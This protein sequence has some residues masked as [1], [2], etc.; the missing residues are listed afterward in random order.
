MKT[1][2]YFFAL[3]T[4]FWA[5][6]QE[7]VT[8]TLPGFREIA[9][10]AGI[11]YRLALLPKE[12]GD[13]SP[14]GLYYRGC[15]VALGDYDGDG[16]DDIYFLNQLGRNALYRNKGDGTFVDVT[17]EA[18]VG[19]GDRIC[20]SATWADYDNS[21]RQS[22]F[23]TSTRGGNVLFKNRGDGTFVDVTRKAGLDLVAHSQ[24][25][26][27]FDYDNDGYLDLLVINTAQWTHN[28]IGN[29]N[30]QPAFGPFPAL[31]E[32]PK[33]RNR[34]YHNNRDGTFSDVTQ[35]S[36]LA[37]AGWSGDVAV[38]D[39]NEDGRLDLLITNMFG[40]SHLYRNN[41]DGTFT[42][43][44]KET[45]GRT[46]WGGMGARAFDFDNDGRLDLLIVDL[47]SDLWAL[48]GDEPAT[49]RQTARKRF[50]HVV[51]PRRKDVAPAVF[52]ARTREMA[53]R[54]DVRP[55]EVVFGNTL[56]RN[57]GGGKFQEV[58]EQA[59]METFL[60]WG[61]ATGDFDNDGY[62]DVFLPSGMGHPYFYWPNALMMN[63]GNGTFADRAGV[64]GIEPPAGGI[65]QVKK[66]DGKP[67][68]RCSRSAA[69]ADFRNDGRLDIVTNNFNDAP[70][71]FQNAFPRKNFLGFR[72]RGTKSNRDAI[73]VLVRLHLRT[74]DGRE[75]IMVRQVN[76]A[77]GYLAQSSKTIHF[78]LGERTKVDRVE[79]RWP[80]GIRQTINSPA[81]NRL[82]AVSEPD[83]G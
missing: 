27:F 25:A 42:D 5:S 10:Q 7:P 67:A 4:L 76:P 52:E 35:D 22:L 49:L 31:R 83:G 8:R 47:H 29:G 61:I 44:T 16:F 48:P 79:I 63:S 65:H 74:N 32:I 21:G 28:A 60:P 71:Y 56:F 75:E 55:N 50:P 45:L 59:S 13:A 58:S 69:V 6:E 2:A 51:G 1:A 43:V 68:A 66:I 14:V 37:G 33:E 12:P 38:F 62:Q 72:L 24:G 78:G 64:L 11:T 34:L 54:L 53:E 9:S 20:V 23:V 15:G 46:S 70:Y 77:G 3:C 18:G 17:K 30:N 73:G 80:S 82:H 41:G 19:L 26:C 40:A 36:G 57:L 39:Y 81:L